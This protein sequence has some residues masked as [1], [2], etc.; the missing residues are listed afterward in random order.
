MA[1]FRMQ[2]VAT[3][4]RGASECE[5]DLASTHDVWRWIES[6]VLRDAHRDATIRVRD[7]RG[8]IVVLTGA[9]A[10]R[11]CALARR[12]GEELERLAIAV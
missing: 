5:A 12:A 3:D 7:T 2:I 1:L 10:A 4:G 6:V 11:T 9:R 8:D